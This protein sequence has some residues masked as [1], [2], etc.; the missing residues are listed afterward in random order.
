MAFAR[1]YFPVMTSPKGR[2]PCDIH[3]DCATHRG[4]PGHIYVIVGDGEIQEG[5]FWVSLLLAKRFGLDNFTVIVDHNKIQGSGRT[6][7]ILPLH[8]TALY[9]IA[10]HAGWAVTAE[11]GH[12]VPHLVSALEW[13]HTLS[14]PSM[15]IAKTI[16]G[17]GVSFMEDSSAWH[18]KYPSPAE[19]QQANEELS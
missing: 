7:D 18:A 19:I 15:I 10:M 3:P 17:R 2:T 11:D 8:V 16:K 1:K 9:Q 5:T 12:D 13:T 4:K 14:T 6:E